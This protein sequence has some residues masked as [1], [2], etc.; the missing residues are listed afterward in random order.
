MACAKGLFGLFTVNSAECGAN[1]VEL[2]NSVYNQ[3]NS[4]GDQ[5]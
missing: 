3:M 4:F 5:L 2:S 1:K